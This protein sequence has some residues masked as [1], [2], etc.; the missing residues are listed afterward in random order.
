VAKIFSFN[1]DKYTLL[2]V[3]VNAISPATF[4]YI[5]EKMKKIRMFIQEDCYIIHINEHALVNQALESDINPMLES[6][7]GIDWIKRHLFICI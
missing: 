2:S 1:D 7:T 4:K 3:Q 6:F 5:F